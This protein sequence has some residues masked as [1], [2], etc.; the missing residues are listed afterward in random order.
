MI[1][2]VSLRNKCIV[3]TNQNAT[4]QLCKIRTVTPPSMI[5][6]KPPNYWNDKKN[7]RKHIDHLSK[8]FNINEPSDWYKVSKRV[9]RSDL[10]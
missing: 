5:R 4:I 6:K 2:L 9:F 7:I 10:I 1:T 3:A 8:V